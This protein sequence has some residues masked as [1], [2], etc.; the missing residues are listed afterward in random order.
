MPNGAGEIESGVLANP[1][2]VAARYNEKAAADA[3]DVLLGQKLPTVNLNGVVQRNTETETRGV[4]Q[5]NATVSLSV[6]FPLYQAGL[7]DAQTRAAKQTA[8][9]SRIDLETTRRQ[10]LQA[11]LQNWSLFEAARAQVQAFDVQVQSAQ[12]AF[13]GV[14][15][16]Q[17][18]GTRTVQEVLNAQQDLF[19]AQVNLIGAQRDNVVFSHQLASSL[20]GLTAVQLALP[21]EI[22][23]PVK[24]YRDSRERW[25]GTSIRDTGAETPSR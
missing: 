16:E 11:A 17:R 2:I 21:V 1:D 13:N 4:Q 8:G 6:T 19:A 3:V 15:A 7:T 9:Q 24:N 20:G 12:V 25:Y 10:V 5:D 18:V 22:Y 23:D 14:Q